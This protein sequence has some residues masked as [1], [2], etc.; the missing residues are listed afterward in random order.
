M[1][2]H[3]H[4]HARC[5]KF[6]HDAK[7]L[8]DEFGVE[9]G[10]GLVKEHE[11]RLHRNSARDRNTLLLTTRELNRV[12]LGLVGQSDLLKQFHRALLRVFRLHAL[13]MNRCFDDVL[14]RGAV[15]KEV[16]VLEHH[17]NLAA[18][19]GGIFLRDLVEYAV[20]FAV[21]D[22][23]TIDVQATSSD[24]FQVI[25]ATQ[26]RGFTGTRWADEAGD[27]ALVYLKVD[28]LENVE[29]AEGLP[30]IYGLN[31][32]GAHSYEF[33]STMVTLFGALPSASVSAAN[34]RAVS[35]RV[36]PRSK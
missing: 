3:E 11:L 30:H 26:E 2:D 5:R 31:H 6:T 13:D 24:L 16:E 33:L 10:G 29:S 14:E 9:G 35:S 8:A 27:L 20:L 1:G 7:D 22:E 28:A 18:L 34:W 15:T 32:R 36:T 25:H 19:A 17:A 4:G 23:L 21:A 12:R